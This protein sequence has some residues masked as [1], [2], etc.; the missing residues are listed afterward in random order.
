MDIQDFK[1]QLKPYTAII[2]FDYGAKRL[3]VAVSDLLQNIATAHSIIY[4]ENW[5]KDLTAIKK[6][7]EEKEIKA[8]VYGLPLQMDGE[9]GDIAKEV[10]T[11]AE[12]LAEE[13]PLPY[14]F[15]DERLSSSA[16]EKF[17]INEV[18]M[19]RAKRKQKL[20]AFAAA[21]ILQGALDRL[22]YIV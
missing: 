12:K 22:K 21:Y 10:R 15:W 8:I 6:I 5:Q 17:L 13:I 11:F 18:D 16:M 14:M 20:D 2:G 7:I 9:E 1:K 4:R 3:G 19:S